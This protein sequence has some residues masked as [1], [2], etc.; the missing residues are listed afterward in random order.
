MIAGCSFS[1]P[2]PT[3]PGTSW[4]EVIAQN[5]GWQV[6]NLAR[7]GCSNGGI[8]IQI[9]E[10]LRQ[11]PDFAIITPTFWDRMEIPVCSDPWDWTQPNQ[12][13]LLQRLEQHLQKLNLGKSQSKGGYNR[14]SGINN[15]NYGHNSSSMICETIFSLAN[16]I[17]HR[18]RKKLL[19]PQVCNALQQ[20]INHLY[21]SD[22]KKQ[23]D[24]WIITEGVLRM[25]HQGIPFV[26]SP[27]LLWPWDPDNPRL[28]RES[29]PSVLPDHYIMLNEPE[30]V[31]PISGRYPFEGQDPGYH[32]SAQGQQVVA[33]NYMRRMREDHG[34]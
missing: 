19:D 17:E 8:R 31:L 13:G 27:V 32:M 15:I 34:I 16:N 26:I 29:F 7:Q 30:S 21:D 25:F 9:D 3:A 11:Q 12:L 1:A 23:L 24:E 5:L 6:N 22:W 18:Y 14:A 10:I 20:Y 33:Q 2:S 4:G 28:W